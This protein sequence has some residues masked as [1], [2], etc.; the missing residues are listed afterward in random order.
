MMKTYVGRRA[1]APDPARELGALVTVNGR[2]LPPRID[3]W[4]HSPSGFE[5]GYAGSGPAQLAL[6][7]L[8]DYLGASVKGSQSADLALSLHQSFKF[9]VVCKLPHEGW[10]L[11]S[12]DVEKFMAT[13]PTAIALRQEGRASSAT[14]AS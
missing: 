6:A 3:L 11:T 14:S 9:E 7:I 13:S 5:W 4:N 2:P 8:A 1:D 12:Q 10:T